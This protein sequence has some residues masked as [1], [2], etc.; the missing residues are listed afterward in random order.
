MFERLKN[1][2][3]AWILAGA[4]FGVG[5][6]GPKDSFTST[7]LAQET[8]SPRISEVAP[9][10]I[11]LPDDTVLCVTEVEGKNYFYKTEIGYGDDGGGLGFH[12]GEISL[13]ASISNIYHKISPLEV[14][15]YY[16]GS[17]NTI[18]KDLVDYSRKFPDSISPG[19][20]SA[21]LVRF[22][23]PTDSDRDGVQDRIKGEGGYYQSQQ[24]KS[25][26]QHG[27]EQEFPGYE[28]KIDTSRWV[29]DPIFVKLD[30]HNLLMIREITGDIKFYKTAQGYR[31]SGIKASILGIGGSREWATEN[32]YFEISAR[33]ALLFL[34]YNPE[35]IIKAA[36]AQ[37]NVFD[38]PVSMEILKE[39][40]YANGAEQ[41]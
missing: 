39:T 36:E 17:L 20:V 27:E 5:C 4:T 30:D 22:I 12:V 16:D 11:R 38:W 24:Q 14:L 37:N 29:T 31:N 33:E 13:D 10:L 23:E 26:I 3:A 40:L 25:R 1:P 35:R 18:Y 7:D 6:S 9:A 8:L 2:T 15:A 19:N 28:L 41:K 34:D 21:Y 32:R